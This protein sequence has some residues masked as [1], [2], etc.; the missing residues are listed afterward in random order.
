[1]SIARWFRRLFSRTRF[2]EDCRYYKPSRDGIGPAI[3][4]HDESGE[5][6]PQALVVREYVPMHKPYACSLMRCGACGRAGK[7]WRKR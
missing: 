2:C 3:C 7:L 5:P 6:D 1:M 4:T